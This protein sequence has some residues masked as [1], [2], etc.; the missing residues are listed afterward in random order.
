MNKMPTVLL[1]KTVIILPYVGM[2]MIKWKGSYQQ[3][4][5]YSLY[6]MIIN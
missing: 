2:A 1:L 4:G 5:Q 6:I 3:Q